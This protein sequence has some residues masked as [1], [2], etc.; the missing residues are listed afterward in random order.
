[1][2]AAARRD[3]NFRGIDTDALGQLVKQ[4]TDASGA[5]RSWLGSHQPPPGVSAGGY[6]AAADIERWVGDQLGMLTRRR[7]FALSHPDHGGNIPT[8]P[9]P[10]NLGGKGGKGGQPGSGPVTR[11]PV[12]RPR[13]IVP[14]G[15]GP[16]LG[17]YPTTGAAVKAATA[18]ALAI[19]K[20]GKQH[21][22]IPVS[23][24]QHLKADA[25]D[26]D[27]ARALIE[28]LGPTGVAGLI[29]AAGHDHT[30]LHEISQ[31]LGTASRHMTITR[32]WLSSVLTQSVHL[33][34]R[35]TA[36]TVLTGA[37]WSPT[38]RAALDKVL[39][40][41]HVTPA[42]KI[43]NPGPQHK[44]V[45]PPHFPLAK[46]HPVTVGQGAEPED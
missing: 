17:S 44:P 20:A 16:H 37:A 5:V 3:P 13:R 6:A 35:A 42:T 2:L 23:V 11:P 45:R 9:A 27:Y 4:V 36:V 38:A 24:W 26:P 29:A 22:P 41:G 33:H 18:D 10:R 34:D 19:E 8:P 14:A 21:T 7:N 1:M 32:S 40:P 28:K 25:K 15:A 39:A 46:D 43:Q 31:A 12:N 30:E